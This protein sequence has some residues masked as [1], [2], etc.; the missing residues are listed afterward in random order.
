M[1][2]KISETQRRILTNAREGNSVFFSY[3]RSQGGGWSCSL[4]SCYRKGL[5][6]PAT[7]EAPFGTLTEAGK[8]A[9]DDWEARR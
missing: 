7:K 6:K 2:V 3:G 8:A 4:V 5:L 1:K 9:L